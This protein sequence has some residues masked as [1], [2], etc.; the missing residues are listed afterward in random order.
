M[1]CL[2]F[3][4]FKL[5]YFI[6]DYEIT[7]PF[8]KQNS[9]LI[10]NNFVQ[11]CKYSFFLV[12]SE[13]GDVKN[14]GWNEKSSQCKPAKRLLPSWYFH[15]RS[16]NS[17]LTLPIV[18][19]KNA[20]DVKNPILKWAKNMTESIAS[21]NRKLHETSFQAPNFFGRVLSLPKFCSKKTLALNNLIYIKWLARKD[22]YV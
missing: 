18:K 16:Q 11:Y 1:T 20:V 7:M 3:Q 19:G 6:D 17:L 15:V 5:Q 8:Q 22:Q 10:V 2:V 9:T 4:K 14:H 13:S 21:E 12:S